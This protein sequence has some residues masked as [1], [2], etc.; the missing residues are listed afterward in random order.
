M[1]RVPTRRARERARFIVETAIEQGV[2]VAIMGDP[3]TPCIFAYAPRAPTPKLQLACE[4]SFKRAV[5]RNLR[6]VAL[7]AS[8]P[9]PRA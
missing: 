1:R 4:A 6:A 5:R 9:R 2:R 7:I 8:K 3:R